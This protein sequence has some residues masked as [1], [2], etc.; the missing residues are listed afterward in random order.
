MKDMMGWIQV[1]AIIGHWFPLLCCNCNQGGEMFLQNIFMRW[2]EVCIFGESTRFALLTAADVTTLSSTNL[3]QKWPVRCIFYY[4]YFF[5]LNCLLKAADIFSGFPI[6]SRTSFITMAEPF[7]CWQEAAQMPLP[8]EF[9]QIS[10][11]WELLLPEINWLKGFKDNL[12][13]AVKSWTELTIYHVVL[14]LFYP[15]LR[16]D[17]LTITKYI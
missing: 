16:T 6:K 3:R 13:S 7:I 5:L 9:L 1:K 2:Q 12:I 15:R 4:F 14:C 10:D 17:G 11:V 8:H